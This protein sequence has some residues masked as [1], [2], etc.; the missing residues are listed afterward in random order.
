MK[1]KKENLFWIREPKCSEIQD[2]KIIIYTDP[3]TDLWQRTYYGFQNE[4]CTNIA[5]Q[6]LPKNI[7]LLLLKQNLK[8]V[9]CLTNAEWFSI[10]IV[11]IG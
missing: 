4:Q 11:K 6:K 2:N 10:W 8:A 9:S 3:E 7:S 5:A 1:F